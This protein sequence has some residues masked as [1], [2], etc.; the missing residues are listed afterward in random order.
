MRL[1]GGRIVQTTIKA[2]VET[3][4]GGRFEVSFRDE[5]AP[6]CQWQI[7]IEAR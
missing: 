2:I 3:T 1:S 7:V 6:I 4:E 5:P